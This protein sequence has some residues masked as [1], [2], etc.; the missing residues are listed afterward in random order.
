MHAERQDTEQQG[1]L[2]LRLI[3]KQF[4]L[5]DVY[6]LATGAVLSSGFS[7]KR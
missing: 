6:A 1:S 3:E 7:P 2:P 5:W 4:G